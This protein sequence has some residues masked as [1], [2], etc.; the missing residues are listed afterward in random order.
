MAVARIL[1]DGYSLLHAWR[2]LAPGKARHSEAARGEL[3]AILR[4]YQDAVGT[5]I[6]LVFDGA[7][8]P[9]WADP[10]ESTPELEI[11]FSKAGKT[12]D[13]LIERVAHRLRPYGEALV[14]TNDGLERETI[15]AVG[16]LTT[17]CEFFIRD[18]QETLGEEASR[19]KAYNQREW[20]RFKSGS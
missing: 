17:S 14:V 12:A 2:E 8:A 15:R 19:M 18:I 9:P 3:I 1:V 6:T 4:R 16:G 20:K 10:A 11:L 7:G 5:P 13:E